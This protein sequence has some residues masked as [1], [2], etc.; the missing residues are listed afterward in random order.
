MSL[1]KASIR[2]RY[3]DAFKQ[4]IDVWYLS[5]NIAW[6]PHIWTKVEK[7]HVWKEKK[8]WYAFTNERWSLAK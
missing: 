6:G 7:D 8:Y 4:G 3:R 1:N 5:N 2:N